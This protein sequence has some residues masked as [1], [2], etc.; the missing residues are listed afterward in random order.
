VVKLF[1][2]GNIV[3]LLKSTLRRNMT[4]AWPH[5]ILDVKAVPGVP[6]PN[7]EQIQV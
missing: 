2:T 6:S 3:E 5:D 4:V 7:L 1:A